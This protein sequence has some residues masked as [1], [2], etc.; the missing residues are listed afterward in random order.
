MNGYGYMVLQ[1]INW[2]LNTAI[3][4]NAYLDPKGVS[5]S[6]NFYT[7]ENR[8]EFSICCS[9]KYCFTHYSRHYSPIPTSHIC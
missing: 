5:V 2:M 7:W 6:S 3:Q 4:N 1:N 8:K 9:N